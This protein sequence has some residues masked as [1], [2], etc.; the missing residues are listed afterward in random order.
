MF[1]SQ[2]GPNRYTLTGWLSLPTLDVGENLIARQAG[3]TV[4]VAAVGGCSIMK[5]TTAAS[6]IMALVLVLTVIFAGRQTA[7]LISSNTSL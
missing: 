7:G 1:V 4:A 2:F 6:K 3:S 5:P